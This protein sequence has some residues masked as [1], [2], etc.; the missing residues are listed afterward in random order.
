MNKFYCVYLTLYFGDKLPKRYIG[1][2]TLTRYQNGYN[3][4][5]K[6]KKY[7][8]LY[9]LEQL[10]NKHL[11]KTRILSLHKSHIEAINEELRLH[12]KYN[13]VKSD[14]Y[15][16]MSLAS[17]NGYFGRDI[18]GNKHPFYEKTHSNK[19]KNKISTTLKTKYKQGEIIS[20]FS[21][22]NVV[23]ENN[24]FYGKTHSE[25]AKAKMRKPKK[26]VPKFKCEHCGREYDA[27]NLKQHHRR[28][29]L[30]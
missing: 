29:G 4:S 19:T 24:P 12:I 3:G 26:F 8:T 15:M 25:E 17:P 20:P 7:K 13:V 30:I 27:G 22:L 28:I 16:N 9:R 6:S 2:T 5:I 21:R 14:E 10:N 23:G 11:F 1:S 18:S